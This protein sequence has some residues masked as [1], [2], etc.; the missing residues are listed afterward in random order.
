MKVVPIFTIFKKREE[1]SKPKTHIEAERN[2]DAAL[3][4]R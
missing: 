4:F 3:L 2:K 1:L